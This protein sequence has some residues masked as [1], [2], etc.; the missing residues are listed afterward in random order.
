MTVQKLLEALNEALYIMV[1]KKLVVSSRL[2]QFL[3]NSVDRFIQAVGHTALAIE[4]D[5]LQRLFLEVCR[6]GRPSD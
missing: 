6:T 5:T 2:T 1:C 3:S 4:T